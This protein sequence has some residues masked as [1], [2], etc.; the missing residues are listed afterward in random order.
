MRG[1]DVVAVCLSAASVAKTGY[2][3]KEVNIA[4]NAAEERPEGAIYVVPIRLD[5][6]R[7]PD[8][9]ARRQWVDLFAAGGYAR[10]VRA[11]HQVAENL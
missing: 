6:C 2:V 11:L 9:L 7:V 5:E 4:L 3:Q 1:A 8:R 10:L